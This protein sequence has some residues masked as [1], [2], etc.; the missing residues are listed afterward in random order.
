MQY[1]K[2]L[3]ILFLLTNNVLSKTSYFEKAKKLFKNKDY[4]K[5]KFLFEKD[6]VF[7]PKN[8]ESYFY[9]AKIHKIN[10]N[11][12]EEEKNLKTVILLNPK[13]SEA[14]YL[15]TLKQIRDGDFNLAKKNAVLFKKFCSSKC[16]NLKKIENLIKESKG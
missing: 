11:F 6:I 2:I 10:K 13:L 4:E 8:F 16:K 14:Y 9:L 3:I 1:I 5:S 7:N 15:L 12:L